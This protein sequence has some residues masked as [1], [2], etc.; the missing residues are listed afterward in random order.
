MGI[1]LRGWH[2]VV[3][4]VICYLVL[5]NIT[6]PRKEEDLELLSPINCDLVVGLSTLS[7]HDE[8]S[9]ALTEKHA[10]YLITRDH[11]LLV[12]IVQWHDVLSSYTTLIAPDYC[13]LDGNSY[14]GIKILECH[15]HSGE[16]SNTA[17]L[18]MMYGY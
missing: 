16:D 8:N 17:L 6:V 13:K 3:F 1:T 5:N 14:D 4:L 18:D 15:I 9:Q 10:C 12:S 7:D 2:Y 11:Y